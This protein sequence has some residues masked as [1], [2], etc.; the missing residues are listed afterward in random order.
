[1]LKKSQNHGASC[2]ISLT[3]KGNLMVE[4]IAADIYIEKGAVQ[5]AIDSQAVLMKDHVR[6]PFRDEFFEKLD[7]KDIL[8]L[9]SQYFNKGMGLSAVYKILYK[10]RIYIPLYTLRWKIQNRDKQ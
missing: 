1:M 8:E 5:N 7:Q 9:F 3:Q 2:I 4:H 6:S 10:L